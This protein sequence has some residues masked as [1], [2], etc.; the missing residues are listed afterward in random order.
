M[1][2]MRKTKNRITGETIELWVLKTEVKQDVYKRFVQIA[3]DRG[4][5]VSKLLG[6]IVREFM[7]DAERVPEERDL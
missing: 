4:L 7:R 1:E 2:L 6:Q 3:Y 5:N